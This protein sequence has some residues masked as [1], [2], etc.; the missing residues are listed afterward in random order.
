MNDRGAFRE[1]FARQAIPMVWDYAE[2]NPFGDAGGSFLT[3][4]DK[5]F[6]AIAVLF[7]IAAFAIWLAP[8][9]TK[10]VDTSAVH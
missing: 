8:R 7:T 4:L 9:P 6:M 10:I 2:S 1:T 3:I 5:I